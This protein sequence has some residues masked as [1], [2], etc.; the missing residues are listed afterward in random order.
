MRA[1]VHDERLE[2]LRPLLDR[3]RRI[4]EDH[5]VCQLLEPVGDLLT[6]YFRAIL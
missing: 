6:R 4:G 1:V 3:R 2:I 5:T